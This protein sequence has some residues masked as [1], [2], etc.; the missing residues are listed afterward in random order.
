[1]RSGMN[2]WLLIRAVTVFRTTGASARDTGVGA[3][4]V[5]WCAAAGAARSAGGLAAAESTRVGLATVGAGAGVDGAGV[6]GAFVGAG[7]AAT[8]ESGLATS[9]A[10]SVPVTASGLLKKRL[11]CRGIV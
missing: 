2:A 7:L 3:G 10:C 8:A 1:M 4:V 9:G 11:K 6:T 5:G